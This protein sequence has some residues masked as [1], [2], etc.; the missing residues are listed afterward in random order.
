MGGGGG[1]GGGG[2]GCGLQTGLQTMVTPGAVQLE[3]LGTA[4]LGAEDMAVMSPAT[5]RAIIDFFDIDMTDSPLTVCEDG[6]LHRAGP[7]SR[8]AWARS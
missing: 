7:V 2:M 4:K 5:T 6:G 1:G 3:C 8:S